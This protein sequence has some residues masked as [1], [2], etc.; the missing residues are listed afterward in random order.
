MQVIRFF[1]FALVIAFCK[2]TWA[3]S[4]NGIDVESPVDGQ[5]AGNIC[6]TIDLEEKD[7]TCN[8]GEETV[9][10]VSLTKDGKAIEHGRLSFT[11]GPEKA[12]PN[13]G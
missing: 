13:V 12:K 6:V 7:W 1:F 4:V 3:Q 11:I 2:L 8:L 10:E 9:F 5:H